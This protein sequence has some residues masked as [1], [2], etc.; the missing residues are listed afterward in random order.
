MSNE[1]MV[2]LVGSL[3]QNPELR[4]VGSN[5][6]A[7]LVIVVNARKFNRDTNEWE[8]RP[9]KFWRCQAWDQGKMRLAQN[10]H[11]TLKDK[12]NVVA[13]GEIV[14][15]EWQDSEG[16]KRSSDEVRI[17]TIGKDLRWHT[18]PDSSAAPATS[19]GSWTPDAGNG[20]WGNAPAGNGGW[21]S[22]GQDDVPF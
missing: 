22:S 9:G 14:T 19:D 13:Y 20:G 11:D 21:P 5:Q 7:N 3:Y 17:E 15:R 2:T 6:V 10:V 16:K 8:K 18:A 4:T 12:D 1:T